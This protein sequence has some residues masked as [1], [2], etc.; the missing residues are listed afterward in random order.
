MDAF[1]TFDQA[2]AHVKNTKPLHLKE[3]I[4]KIK[5]D[6]KVQ[7]SVFRASLYILIIAAESK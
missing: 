5:P 4:F 1:M 2:I 3:I 7:K 6:I